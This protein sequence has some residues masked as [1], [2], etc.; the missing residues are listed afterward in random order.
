MDSKNGCDAIPSADTLKALALTLEMIERRD[1]MPPEHRHQLDE[2]L[3]YIEAAVEQQGRR[4][5]YGRGF[6]SVLKLAEVLHAEEK[7]KIHVLENQ[8]VPPAHDSPKAAP[9]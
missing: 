2:E 7:E 4:Q 1:Q 8:N 9:R 6:E 5:Q 3:K